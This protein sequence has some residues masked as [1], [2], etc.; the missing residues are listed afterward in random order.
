MSQE[1]VVAADGPA[2]LIELKSRGGEVGRLAQ[3]LGLHWRASVLALDPEQLVHFPATQADKA[4]REARRVKGAVGQDSEPVKEKRKS[5]SDKVSLHKHRNTTK[6]ERNRQFYDTTSRKVKQI[7][8]KQRLDRDIARVGNP[9]D[10]ITLEKKKQ[11][12]LSFYLNKL[13]VCTQKNI[14]HA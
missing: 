6:S 10:E 2:V 1:S 11:F 14:I 8:K 7:V 13:K 12:G 5:R 4:R 9:F 3:K